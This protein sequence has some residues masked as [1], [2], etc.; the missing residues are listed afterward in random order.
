MYHVRYRAYFR[1]HVLSSEV[2]LSQYTWQKGKNNNIKRPFYALE[3]NRILGAAKSTNQPGSLQ[4]PRSTTQSR[5]CMHWE[6][7]ASCGSPTPADTLWTSLIGFTT[8]VRFCSLQ[9]RGFRNFGRYESI[10][11]PRLAV[12]LPPSD[13]AEQQ[14]AGDDFR[15]A[16]GDGRPSTETRAEPNTFIC[17]PVSRS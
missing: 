16:V 3:R 8:R 6:Q 2:Q 14:Q 15:E 12:Q 7:P 10:T 13:V 11:S 1:D 5:P 17:F 9:P 4:P